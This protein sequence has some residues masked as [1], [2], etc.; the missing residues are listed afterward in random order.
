MRCTECDY[1]LGEI[2]PPDWY[3]ILISIGQ[4]MPTY[5]HALAWAESRDI[6]EDICEDTA[7]AI[8]AKWGS[9]GWKYH[10]PYATW[11]SWCRMQMKREAAQNGSRGS[12]YV[13]MARGG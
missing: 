4:P 7:L 5:E 10:D 6:P 12:P 3:G 1:D 13:S 8:K 11:Q 2:S 9:K